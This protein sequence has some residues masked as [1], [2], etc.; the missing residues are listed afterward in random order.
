MDACPIMETDG[1]MNLLARLGIVFS[2]AI[3]ASEN[4]ILSFRN[5]KTPTETFLDI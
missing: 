3:G 5:I 4:C 1:G 2:G